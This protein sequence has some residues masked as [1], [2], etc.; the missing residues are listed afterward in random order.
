MEQ[1]KLKQ[2]V[3][4]YLNTHRILTMAT[5]SSNG[6]P[7]ATALEYANDGFIVIVAVRPNSKK[8]QNIK[9]NP[10]VFYEIHEDIEITLENVQNLQALQVSATPNIL[11]YGGEG[12]NDNFDIMEKKF[13]VF[14][15]IPRHKRVI[16]EFTP[17]KIWFLNYAESMFH[18]DELNF[19]D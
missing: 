11:T 13:P 6:T 12:F 9:E 4:H 7:D 5:A 16:L 14:N 19:E 1:D 8:V 15:R 18:R 3:L 10:H 2:K 17:K